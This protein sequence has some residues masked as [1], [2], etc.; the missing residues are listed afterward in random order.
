MTTTIKC[1]FSGCKCQARWIARKL[2]GN[3]GELKVCEKHRPDASKR[4]E[5]M[6][7]L[8]FFYEVRPLESGR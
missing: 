7:H 3:G 2:F 4:P 1:D 5:S 8:P 6:R